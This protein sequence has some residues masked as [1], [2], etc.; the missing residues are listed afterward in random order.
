VPWK[1]LNAAQHEH[2][3]AAVAAR[4]ARGDHPLIDLNESLTR[5]ED[6]I[7]VNTSP[8]AGGSRAERRRAEKLARKVARQA[9]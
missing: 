3:A 4:I 7:R 9:A 8:A 1:I 5:V 2:A 6:G